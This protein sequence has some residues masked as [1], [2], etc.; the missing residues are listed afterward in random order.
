MCLAIRCRKIA[1]ARLS[2]KRALRRCGAAPQV[3]EATAER[4]SAPSGTLVPNETG[5]WSLDY[6]QAMGIAER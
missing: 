4:L 3:V 1:K 5:C 2:Q 6:R